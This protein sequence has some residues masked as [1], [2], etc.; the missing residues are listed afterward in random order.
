MSEPSLQLSLGR[1]SLEF[2]CTPLAFS[3]TRRT[4][5]FADKNNKT[6]AETIHHRR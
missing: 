2:V 4:D 6:L 1:E 5:V 3:T